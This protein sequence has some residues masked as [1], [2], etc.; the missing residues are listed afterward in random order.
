MAWGEGSRSRDDGSSDA[1]LLGKAQEPDY[2]AV[3]VHQRR[4]LLLRAGRPGSGRG[5]ELSHAA[6]DRAG[7]CLAKFVRALVVLGK[8]DGRQ[9]SGS[10]CSDVTHGVADHDG[11]SKALRDGSQQHGGGGLHQLNVSGISTDHDLDQVREL[12]GGKE[13]SRALW[14]VVGHDDDR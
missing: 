9:A 7:S 3:N 4:P 12:V 2:Q 13:F 10:G 14:A 5:R 11:G 8:S 6:D 1:R